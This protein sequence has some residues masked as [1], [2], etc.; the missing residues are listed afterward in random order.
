MRGRLKSTVFRP[1]DLDQSA[2][3]S[4]SVNCL[5]CFENLNEFDYL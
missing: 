1:S 4:S 5:D 2:N 3:P